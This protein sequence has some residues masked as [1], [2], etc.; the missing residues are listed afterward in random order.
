MSLS[1]IISFQLMLLPRSLK[2]WGCRRM[3]P[4]LVHKAVLGGLEALLS[5]CH[6]LP[7]L[8]IPFSPTIWFLPLFLALTSLFLFLSHLPM[9]HLLHTKSTQNASHRPPELPS[10][11]FLCDPMHICAS[12]L[13]STKC[14]LL[15]LVMFLTTLRV[16]S[17]Q[18]S[19]TF[20]ESLVS[21]AWHV[22]DDRHSCLLRDKRLHNQTVM[23]TWVD[24]STH[25]VPTRFF[26]GRTLVIVCSLSSDV[27]RQVKSCLPPTLMIQTGFPELTLEN[28]PLTS[29]CVLGYA[30]PV[31][32]CAIH[33]IDKNIIKM[34]KICTSSQ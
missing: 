21:R 25:K 17:R 13:S 18:N 12:A 11:P 20:S 8:A 9:A 22:T 10:V 5:S 7:F 23:W 19:V 34:Y 29:P 31:C 15:V 4:H 27:A 1:K 24:V 16:F 32:T 6:L 14:N 2:C 3:S 30:P 26:F 28:C 33:K